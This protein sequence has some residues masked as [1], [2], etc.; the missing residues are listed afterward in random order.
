MGRGGRRRR[1][2]GVRYR[3]IAS[4]LCRTQ[5]SQRRRRALRRGTSQAWTT[6]VEDCVKGNVLPGRL[7]QR[8]RALRH[9][10]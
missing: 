1:E 5:G 3:G 2:G 7:H 10:S 4:P 6:L 8:G 9:C